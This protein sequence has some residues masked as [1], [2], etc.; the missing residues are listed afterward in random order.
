MTMPVDDI[1]LVF[2]YEC[3]KKWKS[4]ALTDDPDIRYCDCCKK[5]VYYCKTTK[6]LKQAVQFERC[7]ALQGLNSAIPDIPVMG[8][9]HP[10]YVFKLNV[11]RYRNL[12]IPHKG[13]AT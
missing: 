2:E 3:H 12:P 1:K 10:D 9:L 7:V 5:N 8:F 13:K 4:L 6:A 11:E